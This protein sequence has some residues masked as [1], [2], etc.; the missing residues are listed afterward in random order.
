VNK[1]HELLKENGITLGKREERQMGQGF[2]TAIVMGAVHD[3]D[4]GAGGEKLYDWVHEAAAAHKVQGRK[5][6]EARQSWFGFFIAE[7][8][9]GISRDGDGCELFS[10]EV[11]D[12]GSIASEVRKRW[13]QQVLRCDDAYETLTKIAAKHGV[14]LPPCRMLIVNDYD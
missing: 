4:D 3:F 9:A 14:S 1:W 8:G 12:V 5:R 6:Y 7:N 13:P 10:Y 11:F 2:Y